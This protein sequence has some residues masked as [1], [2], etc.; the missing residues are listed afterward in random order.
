MIAAIEGKEKIVAR[1]CE[2]GANID[3]E[4][5]FAINRKAIDLANRGGHQNIVQILNT[6]R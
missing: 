2:L 1:L 3:L 6:K 5:D 4:N